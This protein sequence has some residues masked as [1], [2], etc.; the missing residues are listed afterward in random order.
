M[1]VLKQQQASLS[2]AFIYRMK[3]IK[4]YVTSKQF[5]GNNKWLVRK[6]F[7]IPKNDHG[8]A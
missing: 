3:Q 5:S 8:I 7:S 2:V 1:G 4:P 6:P